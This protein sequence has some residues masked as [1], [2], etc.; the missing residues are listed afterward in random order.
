MAV[1]LYAENGKLT[2]QNIYGFSQFN[3]G[4]F[5]IGVGSVGEIVCRNI[6]GVNQYSTGGSTEIAGLR[7]GANS[8]I[9]HFY[10]CVGISYDNIAGSGIYSNNSTSNTVTNFYSCY[11]ISTVSHGFKTEG[12][13]LYDCTAEGG[14]DKYAFY[15]IKN[16]NYYGC[17]DSNPSGTGASL[18]MYSGSPS[19][20]ENCCFSG[21]Y[22][23]VM[24]NSS[25][26]AS[27]AINIKNCTIRA[28]DKAI[29]HDF[30]NNNFYNIE[31]CTISTKVALPPI[32]IQGTTGGRIANNTIRSID[33]SVIAII[34][35]SGS[36][37]RP[38]YQGGNVA[39]DCQF[40]YTSVPQLI[41]PTASVKGNLRCY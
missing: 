28:Y 3:N 39:L 36:N 1:Y 8:L 37:G 20:I 14:T 38:Q 30:Y 18:G 7:V 9:S 13:N 6:V 32:R 10:D 41:G 21:Y 40:N 26:A 33:Y 4:V 11:G 19:N 31:G 17:S 29:L 25:D 24:I 35:G 22:G 2:F 34:G 27:Y 15:N 16:S 5:V 12:C 23:I